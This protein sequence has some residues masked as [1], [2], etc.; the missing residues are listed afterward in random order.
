MLKL[1]AVPGSVRADRVVRYVH[2]ATAPRPEMTC[3][4]H[5]S[6][7]LTARFFVDYLE[8]RFNSLEMLSDERKR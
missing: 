1:T 2:L 7:V 8:G 4:S 5:P 6:R 3:K